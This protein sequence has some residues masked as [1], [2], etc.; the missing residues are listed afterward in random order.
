M[1]QKLVFI[2][3]G[4]GADT[5]GA[6]LMLGANASVQNP[7]YEDFTKDFREKLIN[8]GDYYLLDLDKVEVDSMDIFLEYIDHDMLD[9]RGGYYDYCWIR[10]SDMSGE[11]LGR[12]NDKYGNYRYYDL[13]S[14]ESKSLIDKYKSQNNL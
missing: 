10:L 12:V 13:L 11:F 4:F 9:E 1:N 5:Q 8:L 3:S 6:F 7:K 2:K 14:L